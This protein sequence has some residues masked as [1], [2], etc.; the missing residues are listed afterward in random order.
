MGVEVWDNCLVQAS[1]KQ[2]LLRSE[3]GHKPQL[4]TYQLGTMSPQFHMHP[5]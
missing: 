1:R 5:P 3:V 4:C 2:E